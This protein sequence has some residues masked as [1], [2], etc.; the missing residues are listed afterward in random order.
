MKK[1]MFCAVGLAFALWQSPAAF[2]AEKNPNM[3]QALDLLETAL[4]A[5]KSNA[6][7]A[8]P[9][10]SNIVAV[11]T[12]AQHSVQKASRTYKG[13]RQKALEYIE[14]AITE[15]TAGDDRKK[16]ASYIREAMAE[17]R[18]GIRNADRKK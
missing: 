4:T 5:C 8:R 14:A 16:S 18:E 9:A 7:S 3:E 15:L 1:L 13:R 6:P 12:A 17:I 11:L 10:S 2:G